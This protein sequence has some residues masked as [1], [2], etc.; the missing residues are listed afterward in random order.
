MGMGMGIEKTN[1]QKQ[2]LAILERIVLGAVQ[3]GLAAFDKKHAS[4]LV[5]QA[6]RMN[7]AQLPGAAERLRRLAALASPDQSDA[8]IGYPLRE[9][10]A[11]LPDDLRHRV[12]ERH[13][14]RLWAMVT[15][16]QKHLAQMPQGGEP[17]DEAD[18]VVEE[19]LGRVWRL[20]ELRAKGHVQRGLELFA[21]ACERYDDR[22]RDERI[23]QSFLVDLADGAIYVDRA[24]VLPPALDRA[25]A[26]ETRDGA[27]RIVEA[28]VYPGFVNRRIRWDLAAGSSRKIEVGDFDRIHGVAL[29]AVEMAVQRLKE[30]LR[31]P[32]APDDAIQL[33]RVRDVRRVRGEL[34][35]VDETGASL[36]LRDSPLA[37]YRSLG[38][39]ATAVGAALDPATRALEQPVSLLVRFYV[40]LADEA[41]YGQPLAMV[42]GR[43]HI[44]LGT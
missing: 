24:V 44:R 16:G 27:L 29:P 11:D 37:R 13:L 38:N 41:I 34:C 20:D 17:R 8:D 4:K 32:L 12:M 36:V 26:P 25:E 31:D 28:V 14:T 15:R 39:L 22:V 21:L 40:G 3:G 35:A 43:R 2:G 6:R 1:A 30:Q 10:G 18:A 33:V 9:P 5:E 42:V 23:E 7:D 19:L